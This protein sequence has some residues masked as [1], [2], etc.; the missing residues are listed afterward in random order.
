MNGVQLFLSFFVLVLLIFLA[1][2]QGR[3]QKKIEREN[4]MMMREMIA[5]QNYDDTDDDNE[6]GPI[7]SD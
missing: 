7:T 6:S 5:R 2:C 4:N 1:I 3:K